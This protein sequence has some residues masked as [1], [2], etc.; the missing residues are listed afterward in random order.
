MDEVRSHEASGRFGF[1]ADVDGDVVLPQTGDSPAT[2]VPVGIRHRDHNPGDARFDERIG[3]RRGTAEVRARLEGRVG[4]GAACRASPAWPSASISACGP[5]GGW[6]APSPTM[7]PS[8]SRTH[9]T[10]GFG[11]VRRRAVAASASA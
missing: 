5:P 11:G 9:P 3:A 1:Y 7:T 8:R 4:G 6:V 10:H 2:H